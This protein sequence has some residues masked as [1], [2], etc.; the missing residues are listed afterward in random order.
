MLA[1][2]SS[3]LRQST[4]SAVSWLLKSSRRM[5]TTLRSTMSCWS[6]SR[7]SSSSRELRRSSTSAS[8][9]A[10]SSASGASLHSSSS[11]LTSWLVCRAVVLATLSGDSP[12]SEECV[13][14]LARSSELDAA[15][16]GSPSSSNTPNREGGAAEDAAGAGAER[17]DLGAPALDEE[18]PRPR[19][20]LLL[21]GRRGWPAWAHSPSRTGVRGVG[22]RLVGLRGRASSLAFLVSALCWRAASAAA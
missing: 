19:W 13:A 1:G 10:F 20:A 9:T 3:S 15:A 22:V 16:A 8:R 21:A 12:S 7:R 17:Q 6:S 18:K 4:A 11:E 2:A 5:P 14:S